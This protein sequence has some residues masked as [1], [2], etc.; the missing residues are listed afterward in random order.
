MQ[1]IYNKL[2]DNFK[3]W[4]YFPDFG[5]KLVFETYDDNQKYVDMFAKEMINR[6]QYTF[7]TQKYEFLKK[8]WKKNNK[9]KQTAEI[10]TTMFVKNIKR[11][12]QET[13]REIRQPNK[14]QSEFYTKITK[15]LD[16]RLG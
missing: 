9:S 10:F 14:A 5:K 4:G 6:Y 11:D 8:I 13:Y 15:V 3:E 12:L 7:E 2:E 16:K 1:E